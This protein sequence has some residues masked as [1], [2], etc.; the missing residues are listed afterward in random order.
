M[1]ML[2]ISCRSSVDR[3]PA[4]CSGGNGY[5]SC[6]DPGISLCHVDQFTFHISLP[7]M[8]PCTLGSRG[9]FFSD[10]DISRRSRVNEAFAA[11]YRYQKKISSGTQGRAPV[12]GPKIIYNF[13]LS[14]R[15]S[16]SLWCF[17]LNFVH[18]KFINTLK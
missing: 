12:Q 18:F 8:G 4:R 6:L 1:T 17:T 5:E 9:Y 7:S 13:C 14:R 3:A 10:I 2:S 15:F 11:K 16:I